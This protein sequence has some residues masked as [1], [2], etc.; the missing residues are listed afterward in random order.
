MK[1]SVKEDAKIPLP[2]HHFDLIC[3]AG[4]GGIIAIMLGRLHMVFHLPS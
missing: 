4:M 3:G 2:H 1:L